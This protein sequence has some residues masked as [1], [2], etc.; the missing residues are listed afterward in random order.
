[1][2]QIDEKEYM[3]SAEVSALLWKEDIIRSKVSN[4]FSSSKRE[5]LHS[6]SYEVS[7]LML[8]WMQ[9]TC[10]LFENFYS[11]QECAILWLLLETVFPYR[12]TRLQASVTEFRGGTNIVNSKLL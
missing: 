3:V 12:L 10:L 11:Y 2:V 4:L 6:D 9:N 7:L 8:H 5:T 1:M